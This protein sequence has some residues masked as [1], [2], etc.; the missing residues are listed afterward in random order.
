MGERKQENEG[1]T[2]GVFPSVPDFDVEYRYIV[3]IKAWETFVNM[4]RREGIIIPEGSHFVSFTS[5]K[6]LYMKG[7]RDNGLVWSYSI[8]RVARSEDVIEEG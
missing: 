3:H 5:T 8:I 7:H 2:Q 4:M 1:R 6:R